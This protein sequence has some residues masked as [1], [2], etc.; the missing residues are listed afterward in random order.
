VN[1]YSSINLT[2]GQITSADYW[3]DKTNPTTEQA[4]YLLFSILV[5]GDPNADD[6]LAVMYNN[7]SVTAG[8]WQD[9]SINTNQLFHVEGI[10]TGLTNPS[11]I[12]LAELCASSYSPGVTYGSLPVSYVRIGYGSGGND[13]IAQTAYVDDL[14]I[15][16]TSAAGAVPEPATLT[17][18][19]LLGVIGIG[20]TCWRRRKAV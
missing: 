20:L 11:S 13:G 9:V 3:V 14:S 5:P 17:I 12:T 16:Y 15:N 6:C 4:P 19:S 2:L 8:S 10:Q 7:P 18:W 1:G